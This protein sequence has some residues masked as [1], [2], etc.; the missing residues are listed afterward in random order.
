MLYEVITEVVEAFLDF[1]AI[2]PF[3]QPTERRKDP[4]CAAHDAQGRLRFVAQD[5]AGGGDGSNDRVAAQTLKMSGQVRL[6]ANQVAAAPP[7]ME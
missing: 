6:P 2:F 1:P 7:A 3:G 5:H 4:E